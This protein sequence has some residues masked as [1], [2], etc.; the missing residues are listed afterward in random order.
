MAQSE[1]YRFDQVAIDDLEKDIRALEHISAK[2]IVVSRK[3]IT[4]LKQCRDRMD[5]LL[6]NLG[7]G[8]RRR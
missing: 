6:A 8:Q 7:S 1:P 5:R 3:N 4:V 2:G